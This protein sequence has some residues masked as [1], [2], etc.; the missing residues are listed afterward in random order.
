MRK[1]NFAKGKTF[2]ETM[3]VLFLGF[4]FIEGVCYEKKFNNKGK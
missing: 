3:L 4:I 2:S 1:N